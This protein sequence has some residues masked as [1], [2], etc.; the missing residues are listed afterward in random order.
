[1]NKS[2]ITVGTGLL[3]GSTSI[4]LTGMLEIR[5]AAKIAL[6]LIMCGGFTYLA[7]QVKGNDN[8]AVAKQGAFMGIAFAQGMQ[9]SKEIMLLPSIQ[10]KISGESKWDK[11]LQKSA[12]LSGIAGQ[13]SAGYFDESGNYHDDGM[14][15]YIGSDGGINAYNENGDWISGSLNGPEMD[16]LSA[17]EDFDGELYAAEDEGEL[18]AAED[19]GELYAA[20]DDG[21]L[22]GA[23]FEIV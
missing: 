3:A 13:L 20:E 17:A 18:Y 7:S 5:P 4:G 15:G 23:E 19:D 11:F 14:N 16:Y 8:Y 12:G 10:S 1:M 2:V 21:E 6:N 9:M 22:Y